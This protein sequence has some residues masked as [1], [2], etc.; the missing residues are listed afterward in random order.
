MEHLVPLAFI[1][2]LF[3]WLVARLHYR[4]QERPQLAAVAQGLLTIPTGQPYRPRRI[5]PVL[6]ALGLGLAIAT[7]VSLSLTPDG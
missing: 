3:T 1:V 2:G 7:C 5:V 4:T 6:V